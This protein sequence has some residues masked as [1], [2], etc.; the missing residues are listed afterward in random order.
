MVRMEVRASLGLALAPAH[1]HDDVALLRAADMALYAAK[2]AGRDQL[3]VYDHATGQRAQ[4]RALLV[5]EL[6]LALALDQLAL[7]FQPVFDAHTGQPTGAEAL[8]RWNHPR[9]GRLAPGEFIDL[10][11]ESGLITSIG[12][13]VLRSACSEA[14]HW[15]ATVRVAVNLSVRQLHDARIVRDVRQI[16]ADTGLPATRLELEVT[17]SALADEALARAQLS[18]LK[19]L[20]VAL[21]LD[22]F[23]TGYSSLSYLQ[24][25]RFDRLKI[26]R[27]F[28]LPL[29]APD[30][31]QQVALVKAVIDLA[32]ALQLRCTA[33]GIEH[34][35]QAVALRRLGCD[36]LQGFSLGRPLSAHAL[37]SRLTAAEAVSV[38][39]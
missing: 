23:G 39:A 21:A 31:T 20:G 33:E 17:E 11:E 22:D 38:V 9:L 18:G 24:R 36:E 3:H 19:A 29:Q 26:D 35:T 27:A 28:V 13:W 8:L 14:V 7:E 6:A 15:P 4:H 10:A 1:G 5:R 37:R 2:A 32:A 30:N 25:F 12:T 34:D 16:L